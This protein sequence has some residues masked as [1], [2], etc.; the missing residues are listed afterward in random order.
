MPSYV[1]RLVGDHRFPRLVIRDKSRPGEWFWTGRGW[2]R[3]LR[4][5]LLFASLDDVN[6][7]IARLYADLLR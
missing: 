1:P 7:T 5:A 3:R 2:S 6:R 4:K